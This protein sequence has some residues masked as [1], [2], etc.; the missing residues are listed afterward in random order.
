MQILMITSNRSKAAVVLPQS[1]PL[2]PGLISEIAETWLVT[3]TE[4]T[5]LQEILKENLGEQNRLRRFVVNSVTETGVEI[6]FSIF[7]RPETISYRGSAIAYVPRH[8]SPFVVTLRSAVLA[9]KTVKQLQS[10]PNNLISK[11]Q[12]Q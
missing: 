10:Y 2:T 11:E 5:L 6:Q 7:S 4:P 8:R 12:D 1:G 9:A 3:T